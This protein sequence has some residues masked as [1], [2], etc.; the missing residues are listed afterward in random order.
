MIWGFSFLLSCSIVSTGGN[1]DFHLGVIKHWQL[2]LL[3]LLI[4]TNWN[5]ALHANIGIECFFLQKF[6]W[7][8]RLYFKAWQQSS[9]TLR[10]T[11]RTVW[12]ERLGALGFLQHFIAW[13]SSSETSHKINHSAHFKYAQVNTSVPRRKKASWSNH[14]APLPFLAA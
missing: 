3:S 11:A 14:R 2:F 9:R 12:M 7:R 5:T 4:V 10:P 8:N 13:F 6:V 1:D